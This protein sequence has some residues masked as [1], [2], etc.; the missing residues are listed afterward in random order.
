VLVV[1]LLALYSP[2]LSL[3]LMNGHINAPVGILACFATNKNLA[4]LGLRNNLHVRITA[5]VAVYNHFDPIDT[6]VVF[7]KFGS[8]FIC[9]PS[10]SFC[11]FNM[12]TADCK[13]QYYSP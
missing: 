11:Y 1:S 9:V 7:G 5:L 3:K 6:T 2:E 12:F 10:D 4:V 8:L 13:K